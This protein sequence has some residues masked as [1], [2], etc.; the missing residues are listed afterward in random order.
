[1]LFLSSSKRNK[2]LGL[3]GFTTLWGP[4]IIEFDDSQKHIEL[5]LIII[6]MN[7][8]DFYYSWCTIFT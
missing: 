1:M 5:T 2:M 7:K 6:K 4:K 8:K 3:K